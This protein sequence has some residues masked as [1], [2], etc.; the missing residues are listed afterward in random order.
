[1][2]RWAIRAVRRGE[3][4]GDARHRLRRPLRLHVS[5]AGSVPALPVSSLVLALGF[6]LQLVVYTNQFVFVYDPSND[7]GGKM[8]P[9]FSGYVVVCMIISQITI[10]GYLGLKRGVMAPLIV[11]LIVATILFWRFLSLQHFRVAETLPMPRC[12]KVDTRT[13]HE[14]FDFVQGKYR[15]KALSKVDD[16]VIGTDSE[17]KAAAA[18]EEESELDDQQQQQQ[19][20]GPARSQH[21]TG[22]LEPRPSPP[23]RSGQVH[24]EPQPAFIESPVIIDVKS[25]PVAQP[26]NDRDDQRGA[27]IAPTRSSSGGSDRR[28]QGLRP[29]PPKVASS[30][31]RVPADGDERMVPASLDDSSYAIEMS[32]GTD[33]KMMSVR[34]E[35]QP[36][37]LPASIAGSPRGDGAGQFGS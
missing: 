18:L 25:T 30:P 27:G 6:A 17:L 33:V 8:W 26:P 5:R 36:P 28:A 35:S 11:P 37:S 16:S 19:P 1:M 2:A 9:K 22:L 14:N 3:A 21:D 29:L 7:T 23:G 31:R 24:P 4:A 32:Q 10:L 20:D 13:E 15:Q 12:H 34:P